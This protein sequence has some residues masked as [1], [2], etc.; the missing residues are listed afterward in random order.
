L[1][2]IDTHV[3]IWLAERRAA[4]LSTTAQRLIDR[5]ELQISP[6]VGMEL[7][8]L[9]QAG[10][11]RSEPDRVL[12]VLERDHGVTRSQTTF[13]LVIEAARTFAWTRDPFDRLIVANAMADRV[14]LLTADELILRHFKD[15]VW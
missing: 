1:I 9:G 7:E 8:T 13:D 10:K 2:H 6:M 5:E 15:A 11:L 12:A 4:A 3:A 14:R